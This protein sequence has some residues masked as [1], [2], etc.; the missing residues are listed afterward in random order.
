MSKVANVRSIW[1]TQ[2]R[3]VVVESLSYK[4]HPSFLLSPFLSDV[5]SVRIRGHFKH[6]PYPRS[7]VFTPHSFFPPLL[8]FS[9][10][11]VY[12]GTLGRLVMCHTPVVRAGRVNSPS[13]SRG[14]HPS[15]G[16]ISPPTLPS[17]SRFFPLSRVCFS[18]SKCV[19]LPHEGLLRGQFPDPLQDLGGGVKVYRGV[20]RLRFGSFTRKPQ[21]VCLFTFTYF[22]TL[23]Q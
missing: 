18:V 19:R 7:K 6:D 13:Q 5:S 12:L 23:P 8:F 10:S 11:L 3:V 21:R 15:R 1:C 17:I 14:I 9:I 22:T 4:F 2:D 20:R 16:S